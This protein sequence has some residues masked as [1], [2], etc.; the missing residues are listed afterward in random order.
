VTTAERI[1]QLWLGHWPATAIPLALPAGGAS[2]AF[3]METC[4]RRVVMTTDAGVSRRL[5]TLQPPEVFTG[6]AAY[7]FLIEVTTG[8]RS[9]VPGETNVFG[10]FKRAWESFRSVADRQAVSS[11]AGVVAQAIRDTRE[12]R[13]QHLQHVGGASY[14]TLARQLLKPGE[15]DRVLFVGAGEL[16]RSMLPFFGAFDIGVW[17]RRMPGPA[18]A[19]AARLFA[20]DDGAR[21]AEWAHHVIVTTP[22]DASNDARWARWLDTSLVLTVLHLG[23]RHGD[24]LPAPIHVASYDL[25]DLFELRRSRDDIRALQLERARLACQDKARQA[26]T[27]SVLA[28]RRAA[29]A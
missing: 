10:Q 25:D 15:G 23:R 2:H 18:F 12:I 27:P 24:A 16:A 20:P 5:A 28:P 6:A 26:A 3:V 17:N 21:A 14:G 7:R 29:T 19:A 1:P 11:L 8:L 22:A 4:L 13:H 9:A